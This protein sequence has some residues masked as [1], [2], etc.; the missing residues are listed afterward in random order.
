[1]HHCTYLYTTTQ[2][3]L[4][5]CHDQNADSICSLTAVK[6]P[7]PQPKA[8]VSPRLISAVVIRG[9]GEDYNRL[10]FTLFEMATFVLECDTMRLA[11][12]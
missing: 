1:M 3:Y 5:I 4:C 10:L 12:V 11:N 6:P 2:N 8:V 7:L 9:C